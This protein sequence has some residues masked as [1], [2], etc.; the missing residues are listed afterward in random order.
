[1]DTPQ[2]PAAAPAEAPAD[3]DADAGIGARLQAHL[4]AMADAEQ[5]VADTDDV[6]AQAVHGAAPPQD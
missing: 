6:V 2:A 5:S 4:K 3:A 1:M